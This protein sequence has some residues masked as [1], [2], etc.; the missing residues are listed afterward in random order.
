VQADALCAADCLLCWRK[1]TA[2]FADRSGLPL[3]SC[4]RR[5]G[6]GQ[7]IEKDFLFYGLLLFFF[8]SYLFKKK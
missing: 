2:C 4:G 6:H 5:G 1:K 3:W 7:K 8:F